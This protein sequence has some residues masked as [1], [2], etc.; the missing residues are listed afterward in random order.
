[1]SSNLLDEYTVAVQQLREDIM[2]LGA[3]AI[4][5]GIDDGN[6]WQLMFEMLPDEL[7]FTLRPQSDA[8]SVTNSSDDLPQ[9][10]RA[11]AMAAPAGA[12]D[13][14]AALQVRLVCSCVQARP[15]GPGRT[16]AFSRLRTRAQ[17]VVTPEEVTTPFGARLH[18]I[19]EARVA[20]FT[21]RE[22]A[23]FD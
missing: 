8:K 5:A 3:K 22:R 14:T 23:R 2:S 18:A 6:M 11:T 13:E 12:S 4:H 17:A 21:P 15:A 19:A 10:D 7:A 20:P 1:M 9:V 16:Q